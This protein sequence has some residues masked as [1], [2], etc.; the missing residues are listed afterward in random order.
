MDKVEFSFTIDGITVKLTFDKGGVIY[1]ALLWMLCKHGGPYGALGRFIKYVNVNYVSGYS[2]DSALAL[3]CRY[4]DLNLV[5]LL[6][7]N[8][9]DVTYR[10]KDGRSPLQM[11]FLNKNRANALEIVQILVRYGASVD[12]NDELNIASLRADCSSGNLELEN[13][14]DD[15]IV[16]FTIDGTTTNLKFIKDEDICGA[17]LLLLCEHGGPYEAIQHIVKYVDVNGCVG[18]YY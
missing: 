18:G 16:S 9:A 11:A 1:G 5:E 10:N 15:V 2:M 3:A 6:V 7:R 17:L 14:K 4:G 13:P 8:D 12:D